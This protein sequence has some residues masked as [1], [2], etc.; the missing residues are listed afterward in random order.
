M[1]ARNRFL[2]ILLVAVTFVCGTSRFAAAIGVGDKAP[3]FG[4][5]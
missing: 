1:K 3:D 2:F 4:Q 5:Q